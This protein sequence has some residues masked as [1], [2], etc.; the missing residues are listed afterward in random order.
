VIPQD[1][2]A[3]IVQQTEFCNGFDITFENASQNAQSYQWIIGEFGSQYFS[4]ETSPSMTFTEEGIYPV[5]LVAYND[6][7]CPDT[8]TQYFEIYPYMMPFF[9]LDQSVYCFEGNE[10]LVSAGGTFQQDLA[11]IQWDFGINAT[12]PFSDLIIPD[13]VSYT[14]PG[15]YPITLTMF[16]NGCEKN[17]T[18]IVEVHPDPKANFIISDSSGCKP[19]MVQFENLSEAWTELSY[20]WDFGNGAFSIQENPSTTYAYSGFFF[21]SLSVATSEGCIGEDSYTLESPIH[22][23][24]LPQADFTVEPN[25]VDILDPVIEVND[26]SLSSIDVFYQISN[27]DTIGSADFIYTFSDAGLWSITQTV[28]N[29]YGCT[30]TVTGGV[31]V[32]GFL[33]FMPNAFTPNGD[34]HNDVL[35]PEYTGILTYLF[36]VY[37]RW[38]QPI[39]TSNDPAKGWDGINAQDG[40]YNYI[41]KLTDL[42]KTPYHYNGTITLIR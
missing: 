26:Y 32:N 33:F 34:G 16:E 24:P 25:V 27:G 21:P 28:W 4:T 11:I 35:K 38:G 1:V 37:D 40:V 29:S 30:S 8:V 7:A 42:T 15:V 10:I 2:V 20:F 41:V 3:D 36:Q 39:F 9:E 18:E 17:W 31:R 23:F 19:L 6:L 22:V 14:E 13:A 5:M 12:S